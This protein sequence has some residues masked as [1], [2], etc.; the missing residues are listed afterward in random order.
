M[1]LR[2]VQYLDF[3][4]FLQAELSKTSKMLLVILWRHASGEGELCPTVRRFQL[5]SELLI[6]NLQV[7]PTSLELNSSTRTQFLSISCVVT[8]FEKFRVICFDCPG[9]HGLYKSGLATPYCQFCIIPHPNTQQIRKISP[10]Y[11]HVHGLRGFPPLQLCA[12]GS[13]DDSCP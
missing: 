9:R 4:P 6:M 5:V 3:E 2:C 13:A 12:A 10:G 7:K 8:W 1:D 11:H